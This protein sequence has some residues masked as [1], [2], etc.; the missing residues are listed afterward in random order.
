ML[1]PVRQPDMTC[2]CRRL[3][4]GVHSLGGI[5]AG[6]LAECQAIVGPG[7]F[8]ACSHVASPWS[9]SPRY[10]HVGGETNLIFEPHSRW[11]DDP[12]L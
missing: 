2:R 1:H 5:D 6:L 3:G 7:R 4:S 12:I 11:Q 8:S 10:Q 9:V